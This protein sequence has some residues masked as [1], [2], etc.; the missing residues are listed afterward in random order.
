[1]FGQASPRSVAIVELT[2][3][4]E[5]IIPSLVDALPEGTRADV[6]VNARCRSVRGD[7]FS[8]I[9]PLSA[10]V[11][12]IEIAKA[13]DWVELGRRIDAGGYDAL[14]I[15]TFQIEGV[16]LWAA[17]RDLPVIGVV[18]NPKIFLNSPAC[19]GAL[20][21]G[22]L[23]TIVLAPHV[24][25]RFN[26][27]TH[28]A[29]MDAISVIEPVF[30]GERAAAQAQT[31]TQ[32][33]VIVPGG[34]NFAARDFDGLLAALDPARIAIMQDAGV[35]LQ[36]I[37]GG[38]DRAKLEDAL[39][40]RGLRNIVS[41][42]ALSDT[43]RVPY[44]AYVAALEQAWAIYPLLPLSWPPYRDYKITSAIPTAIGFGLPFVTDRWTAS[45]YRVPA[46]I[47]DASTHAALDA[48]IGLSSAQ[49]S[50]VVRELSDYRAAARLRNRA[51][52]SRLMQKNAYQ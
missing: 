40:V 46:L 48:L 38:P 36:I 7:I 8:Q 44:D 52:M 15:S 6:F 25:A 23:R 43:G 19:K 50:D 2:G 18:H 35:T 41:L 30:W 24:A 28:G 37:G 51:E 39:D 17:A 1:M 34:I 32:K 12:Y 47:A 22:R 49:H 33:R 42:L 3:V 11:Q 26:T 45:A 27:M 10:Q 16:A 4:H 9:G 29:H 20:I 14:I 13:I 5:E 21:E 31:T